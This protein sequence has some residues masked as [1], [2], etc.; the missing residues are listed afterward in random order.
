MTLTVEEKQS[1]VAEYGRDAKDT[2]REEVQIALLTKDI[3]ELTEHFK[4]HK[5]D[6]HSRQGFIR[7]INKRRNLLSYLRRKSV[8]RYSALVK[9]LGLRV[10]KAK[11]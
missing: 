1:I 5:K 2:G 11:S 4:S 9:V 7:K 10:T 3:N 8:E 6:Q